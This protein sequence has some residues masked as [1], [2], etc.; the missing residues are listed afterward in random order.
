MTK[1]VGMSETLMI[2]NCISG[3]RKSQKLLY[4]KFSVKM[5]HACLRFTKNDVD[6][7]DILQD[8]FAR[9]FKNLHKYRGDGCFEG[10]V[11]RIFI[12]I[13]IEHVKRR[14]VYV[15]ELD[16]LEN[17]LVAKHFDV[18]ETL[19]AKD[20]LKASYTISPGCRNVFNLYAVG[21]FTHQEIG[22]KLGITQSTSKS[23]YTRA[24]VKLRDII[25]SR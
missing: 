25:Q 20:L 3:D 17:L 21:G 23:Q 12:N 4:D 15:V 16:G 10:W 9:L 19:Y 5:R 18:L 6:L 8:S 14:K 24:K 13:S 7:E 1:D 2:R 11:R 22:E